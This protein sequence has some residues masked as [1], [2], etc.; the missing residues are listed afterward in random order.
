VRI[1]GHA[2]AG[3]QRGLAAR[4]HEVRVTQDFDHGFGHAHVIRVV[5]DVLAGAS[6][7]R[8]RTGLAAAY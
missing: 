5:D 3:W 8:P 2:P 6:D 1:E 4:K 7:P